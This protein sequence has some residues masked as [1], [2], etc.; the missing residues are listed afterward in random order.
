MLSD[1]TAILRGFSWGFVDDLDKGRLT[2]KGDQSSDEEATDADE[3]VSAA[4]VKVPDGS[5]V[6]SAPPASVTESQPPESAG[7]AAPDGSAAELAEPPDIVEGPQP[8]VNPK[9]PDG[10]DEVKE[11]KDLADNPFDKST[12]GEVLGTTGEWDHLLRLTQSVL[13]AAGEMEALYWLAK[14]WDSSEA[15]PL[16]LAELAHLGVNYHFRGSAIHKRFRELLQEAVQRT[17]ELPSEWLPLLAAAMIRPALMAPDSSLAAVLRLIGERF[18]DAREPALGRLFGYDLHQRA[19]QCQPLVV[20]RSMSHSLDSNALSNLEAE[21]TRLTDEWLSKAPL[22]TIIYQPATLVWRGLVGGEGD[23]ARLVKE[24]R[25][26]GD[27]SVLKRLEEQV[28]DWQDQ[29]FVKK[30]VNELKNNLQH[31]KVRSKVI[32]HSA[33]ESLIQLAFDAAALASRWLKR[34][35]AAPA[36]DHD[37]PYRLKLFKALSDLARSLLERLETADF[38]SA[39][40]PLKRCLR[41]LADSYVNL[42]FIPSWAVDRDLPVAE[43][44][45]QRLLWLLKV[46]EVVWDGRGVSLTVSAFIAGQGNKSVPADDCFAQIRAGQLYLAG[47][48]LAAKPE[49]AEARPENSLKSLRSLLTEAAAAKLGDIK[50]RLSVVEDELEDWYVRGS[51]QQQD[52]ES[53]KRDLEGLDRELKDDRTLDKLAG[54][55]EDFGALMGSVGSLMRL[56]DVS[57]RLAELDAAVKARNE[58]ISQEVNE[59]AEARLEELKRQDLPPEAETFVRKLLE[60]GEFTAAIDN[61]THLRD[62]LERGEVVSL[63]PSPA[64]DYVQ[65]FYQHLEKLENGPAA[66]PTGN[67]EPVGE[68]WRIWEKMAASRGLQRESLA[69]FPALLRWLGFTFS[70]EVVFNRVSG[71]GPPFYW[72]QYDLA[73]LTID[74]GLPRWGSQSGGKHVM[75]LGWGNVQA[76]DIVRALAQRNIDPNRST[77]VFCFNRLGL[78]SREKLG[79][80]CRKK[81]LCP[82]VLDHNLVAWLSRHEESIDRA[83]AFFQAGLAG[84]AY[85]PYAQEATGAVPA[86]MF[87][88]RREAMDQLWDRNG[89]C[90]VYGG[91]Q[92]GK[93]ALL[94]QL[95]ERFHRP[96]E[97]RYVLYDSASLSVSLHA[98]VKSMLIKEKLLKNIDFS[99]PKL[100]DN[101]ID[102]WSDKSDK[103]VDRILLLI[104][105]S[106]NLLDEDRKKHFDQLVVYRDIM[107]KTKRN[108]K[109]VLAGLHSVQRYHHYPNNPL[110]HFGHP[111]CVGPLAPADAHDLIV[112]PMAQLGIRFENHSLV[113]RVLSHTN[114]HPSLIQLF[115]SALVRFLQSPQFSSGPPPL[116]V[117][118][119]TIDRVYRRTE[120]QQQMKER[121]DWTLDLD[122]RYRLIGYVIAW[123]E[124]V[125]PPLESEQGYLVQSVLPLLREFWPAA[126]HKVDLDSAES[127]MREM[128]G[129]GLLRKVRD[130]FALRSYNVLR[131]LGG[132]DAILN[133]LERFKDKPYAGEKGPEGLR[134]LLPPAEQGRPS[135]L[136]FHQE[137]FFKAWEVSLDLVVGSRALGLT[138]VGEALATL[139][140]GQ[141][142][143]RVICSEHDLSA[144]DQLDA[145]RKEYGRVKDAAEAVIWLIDSEQTRHFWTLVGDAAKWVNRQSKFKASFK[146]VGL[147]H[148]NAWLAYKLTKPLG[149][150]AG[151]RWP[152]FQ[153]LE[154]W[155]ENGLEHWFECNNLVG[156]EAKRLLDETGGWP[157]LLL[158][159]LRSRLSQEHPGRPAP[160]AAWGLERGGGA[161]FGRGAGFG[162]GRGAG[163]G[164]GPVG[165]GNGGGVDVVRLAGPSGSPLYERSLKCLAE[166][167]SA[168]SSFDF[169]VDVLVAELKGRPLE[170]DQARAGALLEGLIQLRLVEPAADEPTNGAGSAGGSAD[171]LYA[172]DRHFAEALRVAE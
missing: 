82:L 163:A 153:F 94:R 115:C 52:R 117:T 159:E 46:P 22:K 141:T 119:Q 38:D 60:A 150:L 165:S 98:I 89:S 49:L 64:E 111:I 7:S 30:R 77:F 32:A 88:G 90:L 145:I 21:L 25:R 35:R 131:L 87:F 43:L 86:E 130:G 44:E 96:Q 14:A 91:R 132:E 137:N 27:E 45:L 123:L 138:A 142:P 169:L 66:Q 37:E 149:D 42:P 118:E 54:V 172:L 3:T 79:L 13:I 61:L 147:V 129:L 63:P 71:E 67:L 80:L 120:L 139:D 33:L 102:L 83:K 126:F 114:Y 69:S 170:L 133:E 41:E 18:K 59:E 6:E 55:A 10:A 57:R 58:E 76:D 65:L 28:A 160:E 68:H 74:G 73:D 31:V 12:G 121:F 5:A 104:D 1:E 84:G 135:P 109:I 101:I 164:K 48:A 127:L 51:L 105:E 20:E 56:Q 106:D 134:R 78:A 9:P 97:G 17:G 99:P 152:R 24:A 23:L 151:A 50:A 62:Q 40:D 107:A 161:A 144:A 29:S 39:W 167:R 47:L 140:D 154:R 81:S 8:I 11:I 122:Q 157:C 36:A 113:H 143:P 168:P 136:V 70:R 53:Y 158:P 26:G 103:K 128:V 116:T 2:F 124:Q 100:S 72:S 95:A 93:S 156:V 16:W 171:C 166:W 34:H 146:I 155:N 112:K 148:P 15:C 108:F 125:E 85:N 92:L 4:G 75:L 110:V 19:V 162:N